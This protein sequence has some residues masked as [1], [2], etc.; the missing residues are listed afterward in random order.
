MQLL[1]LGNQHNRYT[2]NDPLIV[3]GPQSK[4][5]LCE[6]WNLLV[7]PWTFSLCNESFHTDKNASFESTK[8]FSANKYASFETTKQNDTLVSLN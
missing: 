6:M 1:F 4:D 3:S 7:G 5:C 8:Y 2:R